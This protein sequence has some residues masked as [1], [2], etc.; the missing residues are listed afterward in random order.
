[1]VQSN[2]VISDEELLER[3]TAAFSTYDKGLVH[4]R[5]RQ[6]AEEQSA[7]DLAFAAERLPLNQRALI[8][9][10]LPS[11]EAKTTFLIHVEERT[12]KG[13][14]IEIDDAEIAQLVEQMP[15]DEAVWALEDLPMARYFRIL[16]LLDPKKADSIRELQKYETNTAG[17]LMTNEFFAFQ[18]SHTVAA[19]ARY[20]RDNPNIDLLRRIF[21]LDSEKRLLG[22]VPIRNLVVSRP[23]LPL[24]KICRPIEHFVDPNEDRD[25]VLEKFERYRISDLPVIDSTH[26]LVGVISYDDILELLE[27]VAD[28]TLA[29]IAG[30]DSERAY[31]TRWQHFLTRAPWLGVT[32]IGGFITA[33]NMQW[34]Q[35]PHNIIAFVPLI[36]GMSGGVGI[37]S[38]GLMLRGMS[39][40]ALKSMSACV[41]AAYSE[42]INGVLVG[43]AFGIASGFALW[44]SQYLE[45]Y[46]TTMSAWHLSV[47]VSTGL[48]ASCALASFLGVFFPIV[49]EKVGVEPAV[50]AGPLVTAIN[51]VLSTIM[52]FT[53][54]HT[55]LWFLS[56][57]PV[58]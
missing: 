17:R 28:E 16:D 56:S 22:F 2:Q 51:D 54:A 25:Q 55:M 46:H 33:S 7:H 36:N 35:A 1:M 9:K 38:S 24:E 13:L 50:S 39:S 26:R 49:F 41:Q 53:V 3:I 45:L 14:F 58:V 52:Y 5:L 44:S 34:F 19:A 10:S 8:F 27:D 40:G 48:M 30:T 6:I 31:L 43:I 57:L 4:S 42:W 47:V 23:H 32:L 15:P 29:T 20:I 18:A 12:R 21:I 37:Q 11:A